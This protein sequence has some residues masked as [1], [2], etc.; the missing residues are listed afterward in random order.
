MWKKCK[1][2][3][4]VVLLSGLIWVFA[5]QS[6]TRTTPVQVNIELN[7]S[8]DNLLIQLIDG[9]GQSQ[10]YIQVELQVEGP[11]IKIQEIAEQT[12]IPQLAPLTIEQ[13]DYRESQNSTVSEFTREVI[14]LLDWELTFADNVTLPITGARPSQLQFRVLKLGQA[15]LEVKVYDLDSGNPLDVETLNPQTVSAFV[16]V[17]TTPDAEIYLNA[18][19]QLQAASEAI[20]VNAEVKLRGRTHQ[21]FEVSVKLATGAGSSWSEETIP[22]PQ[23]RI[24]IIKPTT[25]VGKYEIENIDE[26]V[27][28]VRDIYGPIRFQGTSQACQDY[29]NGIH[30]TLDIRQYDTETDKMGGSRP[31]TYLIP[32]NRRTE[33]SIIEPKTRAIRFRLKKID[34][35]TPTPASPEKIIKKTN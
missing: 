14:S 7:Q 17:G 1:T 26:F 15:N 33:M 16:Q 11:S 18:A 9:Q 2:A 31:L 35:D 22:S 3:L 13:I 12:L 34:P 28:E 32:D 10:P 19:Q 5:E 6:V 24:N 25:M 4:V 27:N 21:T 29:R 23:I 20:P 8:R 30:L